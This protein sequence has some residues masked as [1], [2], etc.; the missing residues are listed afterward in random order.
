MSAHNAV[1]MS[2]AALTPRF[3][4]MASLGLILTA[5]GLW[6]ASRFLLSSDFLPHWYCLAGNR[7]LLWTTVISDVTIGISYILISTTLAW[8]VRRA[9]G[10]LPYTGF[11]WAFGL[12]IV[13][14]GATHFFEV[15][16]VWRPFYWLAAFVKVVTAVASAG[17]AVVLLIAADDI[18][19]FVRNAREAAQRRGNEKF[20]SLM[21]AAPMPVI[22]INRDGLVEF[23]NPSAQKLFGLSA[24]QALNKPL[25]IIPE[26]KSAEFTSLLERL[27]SG[28]VIVGLETERLRAD[29]QLIPVRISAAPVYDEDRE[30]SGIVAFVED[31]SPRLALER[32][33]HRLEAQ[34]RQSQKMEVLGRLAGGVAHDF[35][36]MLMILG[37]CSELLERAL[38]SE[39]PGL[40]YLAQIQRTT[41]KA[42]AMTRQLLA[43]SRK[44]I[45]EFR[46]I[47][48]HDALADSE[49]M[50]PRLLGSDVEL[51]FTHT[52]QHPWILSDAGQIE[53]MV[54]NLAINSRD[55]MPKGGR[56]TI[57]TRNTSNLP[58]E[59][60]DLPEHA[61]EWV[62]LEV[63]DNGCG[64]DEKTRAQIFEPFFT[65]KPHGKGTG[66][67]LST[68]YGIVKQ[69]GGH[70]HV[71]S[72]LGQGTRFAIYLPVAEQTPQPASDNH[73]KPSETRPGDACT[74]LVADDEPALRLAVVEL[75][76]SSGFNVLE[77]N[78]ALAAVEIA[79]QHTGRID[80][81][82]TD[83][84]MPG[85]RG[86]DLA[87]RIAALHPAIHVIYMSGYAEGF[88]EAEI[89]ENATFL[90][91][92]FRLA[93][94]LE[95]L[96]LV[97][98]KS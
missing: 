39:S 45:L 89:P 86:N 32:E 17:T 96:K 62:V 36:N 35:N 57:S 41:E 72:V 20:R 27:H 79:R 95:Q 97:R 14:C 63:S 82:L 11:F 8:L 56:L 25:T 61:A 88:P 21:E 74:I 64:M 42:A 69:S 3:V 31:I 98:L 13:S 47:N 26:H 78:T 28:E 71:E 50:L 52:A 75:L 80:V 81:L 94:L 9:A 55:A 43:F 83:I 1:Q 6:F 87:Q 77:A 7:H 58:S 93:T 10:E 49:F 84:V 85:L 92:P 30:L 33:Q 2:Q 29:K 48:L 40:M 67:G 53:Q 37:S 38:P 16:T 68:V 54:A 24:H 4:R 65:T 76:R 19:D 46:I 73:G 51:S 66:L 44:Q 70:I 18:V 23:W 5:G 60:V 12:F 22:G 90:Q 15:V 34:I 59:I 91:K